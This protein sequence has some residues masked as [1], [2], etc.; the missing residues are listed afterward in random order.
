M[1]G[2]WSTGCRRRSEK[3]GFAPIAARR[4]TQGRFAAPFRSDIGKR[5]PEREEGPVA[6]PGALALALRIFGREISLQ[7]VVKSLALKE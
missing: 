3:R 7:S 5:V 6:L 1:N 2:R 4:G